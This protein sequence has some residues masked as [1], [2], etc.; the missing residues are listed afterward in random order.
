MAKVFINN[1]NTNIISLYLPPSLDNNVIKIE[2][3]KLKEHMADPFILCMDAN[4]HAG[5]H[6]FEHDLRLHAHSN[7]IGEYNADA[8]SAMYLD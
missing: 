2:L 6:V 4:A 8:E 3:E 1:K 5:T 7:C